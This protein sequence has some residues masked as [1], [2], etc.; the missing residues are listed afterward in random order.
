MAYAVTQSA[1][2]DDSET[3]L[4]LKTVKPVDCGVNPLCSAEYKAEP[5]MYYIKNI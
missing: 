3:Q 2:V 5:N 4:W 1:L